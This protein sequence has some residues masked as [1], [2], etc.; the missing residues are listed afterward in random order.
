[1]RNGLWR[2]VVTERHRAQFRRDDVQVPRGSYIARNVVIGRRTK[3]N[4][5]SHLD[6]CEIGSYCAIAGR[7]VVRPA[8]HHTQ[9]LGIQNEAQV[10]VIGGRPLLAEARPVKIGHGVWIGDSVVILGGVTVGN[11][12]VVGAGSVVT[13][14][15]PAYA[16]A[17]GN[18]AKVLGWRYPEDVRAVLEGVEWWTWD[19][20][21]LRRNRDLFELDLTA[22]DP[23]ELAQRLRE[24]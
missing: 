6:P 11:G 5:P 14:P 9:Y 24:A 23:A 20:E 19:D 3:I 8:N 4:A 10:R 22:V 17:A 1:M 15:V 16:I 12:A 13:K 21:R 7:L 2:M 18:P